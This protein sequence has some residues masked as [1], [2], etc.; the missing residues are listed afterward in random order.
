ML[1]IQNE[2]FRLLVDLSNSLLTPKEKEIVG[3]L[4]SGYNVTAIGIRTHRSAKT[5]SAQK[6]NAYKKLGI[7]SDVFLFPV[8]IKTWGMQVSFY[9]G[10]PNSRE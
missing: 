3:L 10:I 7:S 5:V 9:N 4:L 6:H 1:N 8:L 2:N